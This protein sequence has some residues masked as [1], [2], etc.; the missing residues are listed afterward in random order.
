MLSL[1][2]YSMVIPC[3]FVLYVFFLFNKEKEEENI[4][5]KPLPRSCALVRQVV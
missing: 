2:L 4:T 1:D 3:Y 5:H